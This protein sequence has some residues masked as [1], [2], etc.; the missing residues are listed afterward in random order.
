MK[1]RGVFILVVCLFLSGWGLSSCSGNKGSEVVEAS[2]TNKEG[3]VLEMVYHNTQRT[4]VFT[5]NGE[6]IELKQDTMASG[7]KYS[8]SRYVYSEWHGE[9]SLKKDGKEVWSNRPD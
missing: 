9:M 6:R 2:V 4:A 7:V 1:T 8:N 5:L 3:V